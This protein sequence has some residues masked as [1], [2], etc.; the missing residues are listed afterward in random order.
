M[1]KDGEA[2]LKRI[3]KEFMEISGQIQAKKAVAKRIMKINNQRAQ[4]RRD[5]VAEFQQNINDL[6]R[7]LR[8]PAIQ[9]EIDQNE[10]QNSINMLKQLWKEDVEML[11]NLEDLKFIVE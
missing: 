7:S 8:R 6:L 1:H 3:D 9:V 2:E 4:R 11:S 10:L 5:M